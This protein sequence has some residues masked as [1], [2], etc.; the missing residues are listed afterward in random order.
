MDQCENWEDTAEMNIPL[1]LPLCLSLSPPDCQ[2]THTH[3]HTHKHTHTHTHTHTHPQNT[4]TSTHTLPGGQHRFLL[5]PPEGW[6]LNL[7]L[8]LTQGALFITPS[9]ILRL[10]AL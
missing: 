3:T 10:R 2:L 1:R 5:P 4:H 8:S 6:A 7:G 9:S